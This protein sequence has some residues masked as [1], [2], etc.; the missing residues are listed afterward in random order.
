MTEFRSVSEIWNKDNSVILSLSSQICP[1]VPSWGSWKCW[2]N[3]HLRTPAH[4]GSCLTSNSN[5]APWVIDHSSAIIKSTTLLS[6]IWRQ[7]DRAGIRKWQFMNCLQNMIDLQ[8]FLE[9]LKSEGNGRVRRGEV[10]RS[11]DGERVEIWWALYINYGPFISEEVESII[12]ILK[13]GNWIG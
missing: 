4:Y 12:W 6:T 1:D 11:L 3:T 8:W 7:W 2:A 9:T 10:G 13:L 5:I